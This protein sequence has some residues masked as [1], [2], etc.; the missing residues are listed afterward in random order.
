VRTWGPHALGETVLLTGT[1]EHAGETGKP[2]LTALPDVVVLDRDSWSSPLPGLLAAEMAVDG[3]GQRA[4][5]DRLL[6]VVTISALR[7]WFAARH[8]QAPGWYRA[9]ADFVVGTALGLIHAAPA[10]PWTVTELAARAGVSR[11]ALGRRFTE[12]LGAPP[13][14][15]LTQR[16]L[17]LAAD[18]LHESDATLTSIARQVGYASPFALSAAFKREF[19][20]S[21]QD[22]RVSSP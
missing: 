3:P 22:H 6:D 1:Y 18:L 12:L 19:G 9:Q 20:R 11:A 5:L 17:M 2:L 21:P 4:V 16:R 13:I 7:T 10:H 8:E 15:Y 14:T